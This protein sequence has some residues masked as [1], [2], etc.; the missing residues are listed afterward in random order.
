MAMG[1]VTIRFR[2]DTGLLSRVERAKW[3]ID[4]N[5][6]IFTKYKKYIEDRLGDTP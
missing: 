3:T 1:F 4:R 5:I 6:P 2:I